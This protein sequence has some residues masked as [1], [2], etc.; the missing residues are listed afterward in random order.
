MS[1]MAEVIIALGSN[2]GRP[3]KQLTAAKQFLQHISR[4]ELICSPIYRSE[5][6]GHHSS[7]YLN[8][9][10]RITTQLAPEFLYAQ[11][12]EQEIEQ[13][14]PAGHEKWTDRTLDLD[15]IAYNNLVIET[16]NLIIPHARYMQRLFVLLP[17]KDICPDWKDPKTAQHIN[18]LIESAPIIRITKT[19]LAW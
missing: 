14:R 11:L 6:V 3:H 10:I 2:V 12:K 4:S 17:L 15:L 13:G 18:R 19:N 16:D 9:V 5:S 7:D 8:A 1:A